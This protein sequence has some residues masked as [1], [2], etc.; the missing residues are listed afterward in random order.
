MSR[1]MSASVCLS[2]STVARLNL[3]ASFLIPSKYCASLPAYDLSASA[4]PRDLVRLASSDSTSPG[5]WGSNCSI[6]GIVGAVLILVTSSSSRI[7]L[8]SSSANL[9]SRKL[10]KEF[11]MLL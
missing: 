6:G 10:Q 1:L 11:Q 5:I 3:A 9:S 2:T 7:S 4:C 8:R